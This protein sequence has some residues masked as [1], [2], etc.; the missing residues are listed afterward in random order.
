[1]LCFC[2]M[3]A[4]AYLL[5]RAARSFIHSINIYC[6][7]TVRRAG[8]KDTKKTQT[9]FSRSSQSR[10]LVY[11][12]FHRRAAAWCCLFQVKIENML[13]LLVP[14]LSCLPMMPTFQSATVTCFQASITG[15]FY[16]HSG[17]GHH[18]TQF[19]SSFSLLIINS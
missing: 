7:H 3:L 1:M 17:Q 11:S 19:P 18:P 16:F 13:F 10:R 14:F 8:D 9:L 15:Y 4:C 6:T 5:V 12:T 2:I